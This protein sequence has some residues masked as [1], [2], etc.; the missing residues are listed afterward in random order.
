MTLVISLV[1]YDMPMKSEIRARSGD[2]DRI[3]RCI[4]LWEYYA[5]QTGA[6]FIEAGADY[7]NWAEQAVR[8]DTCLR[9]FPNDIIIEFSSGKKF[10]RDRKDVSNVSTKTLPQF[11]IELYDFHDPHSVRGKY[12]VIIDRYPEDPVLSR[13]LGRE[14]SL[15]DSTIK[16]VSKAVNY[17]TKKYGSCVLKNIYQSKSGLFK[18]DASVSDRTLNTDLGWSII[19]FEDEKNAWFVSQYIPMEYETRFSCFRCKDGVIR[20]A[21]AAGCVEEMTPLQVTPQHHFYYRGVSCTDYLRKRRG[22]FHTISDA[23]V[24]CDRNRVSRLTDKAIEICAN[25]GKNFPPYF[26]MDLAFSGN[27]IVLVETNG[28]LS[29][30]LYADDLDYE[31]NYMLKNCVEYPIREFL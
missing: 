13:Y 28:L 4:K 2:S 5:I 6:G 26:T 27:N 7:E 21:T 17:Y 3:E 19:Q 10:T 24:I 30:G 14:Y 15:V 22:Y 23:N 25:L 11:G 20:P 12:D 29:S 8:L 9:Y 16:S 1:N 18:F 31:I